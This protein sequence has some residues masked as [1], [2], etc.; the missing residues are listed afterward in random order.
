MHW[1]QVF[2]E[3]FGLNFVNMLIV[4]ALFTSVYIILNFMDMSPFID[5][6]ILEVLSI[7][8]SIGWIKFFTMMILDFTTFLSF[9]FSL[10]EI[11]F[12]CVFMGMANALADVFCA[13]S[14]VRKGKYMMGLLTLI[15]GQNFNISVVFAVLVFVSTYRGFSSFDIFGQ[16]YYNDFAKYHEAGQTIPPPYGHYFLIVQIS[17]VLVIIFSQYIYLKINHFVFSKNVS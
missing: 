9:Y 13:Q 5:R 10:S 15:A 8:S 2:L 1:I 3:L 12:N 14:L 7:F 17:F 11:V 6:V 4:D 16:E